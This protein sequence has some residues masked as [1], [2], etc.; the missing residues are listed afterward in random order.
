[1]LSLCERSG[2]SEPTVSVLQLGRRLL[3]C[4]L[5]ALVGISAPI[6]TASAA[7]AF[8]GAVGFG[9]TATGGRGGDVYHVTHLGDA[10]PGSLRDAIA[11]A[12][13]PRTIVF[14][15]SGVIDLA[16]PL[17][18]S[19]SNL[20]LA[21]QTS[22][23]GIATRGYPVLVSGVQDVVI[24]Y[25]R[26]R[27]GDINAAAVGGK[28]SQGNG[29]LVGDAG[30]SLTISFAER[31]IVD[32]VSTSWGMDETLSVTLSSDVTVQHCI[33][34]ESLDDSYHTE[35]EHGYGSLVRGLGLGGYSFVGNLY[36]HHRLRSPAVG[37]EQSPEPGEPRAGLDFEFVN[38]VV[39]D[40]YFFPSHTL[41][42][43]A[44]LRLAFWNNISIKI[45]RDE[46]RKINMPFA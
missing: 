43:Q 32:H 41:L 17:S 25:M 35:G 15:V 14:E 2:T 16:S 21:G 28:P 9:A 5:L 12:S 22:P 34:S 4:V 13:G 11:T 38:N 33:V 10:G 29:D 31:V 39:Y 24:R 18:L 45:R 6:T 1:M 20:T 42:G 46:R 40:W 23:G 3:G 36:S 27:T 37:G 44:T 26:F 7:P 19:A 30:D 8:P